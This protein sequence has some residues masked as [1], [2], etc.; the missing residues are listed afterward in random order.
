V[1]QL[2]NLA[3]FDAA[4]SGLS[5]PAQKIDLKGFAFSS[6]ETATWTQAGSSGTLTVNDGAKSA[7][8]TLIGTYV[9]SKFHL[10]ADGHGG[11][12]V[13]D[14]RSAPAHGAPP[15]SIRLAQS[16]AGLP[17]GRYDRGAAVHAGTSA[18]P[19]TP[20]LIPIGSGG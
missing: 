13:S 20:P 7:S 10:A 11:T 4:I 2:D 9:T 17:G 12:F 3:G 15:A 19:P 5:A 6:G 8:L 14:P 16:I 18:V 1:L